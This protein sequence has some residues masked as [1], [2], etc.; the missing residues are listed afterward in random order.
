[1]HT[2]H[3][4]KHFPAYYIAYLSVSFLLRIVDSHELEQCYGR[5]RH[6]RIPLALPS[7]R[8]GL[9]GTVSPRRL[10]Y[11]N[12]VQLMLRA[13]S[14]TPVG[15][16]EEEDNGDESPPKQDANL[17]RLS[18]PV[19]V[20]VRTKF[21]RAATVLDQKVEL[22]LQRRR[23]IGMLKE[24]LRRVLPNKPPVS[25]MQIVYEGRIQGDDVLI[26]EI[27]E[28]E[29]ED[30]EEEEEE[31]EETKG[32]LVFTLD[33]IPPVDGK[34]FHTLSRQLNDLTTSELLRLYA[35]NEAALYETSLSLLENR[36]TEEEGTDEETNLPSSL[37]QVVPTIEERANQIES[38][39]TDMLCLQKEDKVRSILEETRPP[40]AIQQQTEIR[41]ERI[42]HATATGGMRVSL[43]KKLQHNFNVQSWQDTIRSICLFVFF[44]LFGGR[45]PMKR[46]ILLLGAPS[47]LL[48][49][50]RPV[51]LLW[52]QL[53]YAIMN[54]PPG[55]VLSLL[56][57]P[58]QALFHRDTETAMQTLYGTYTTETRDIEAEKKKK[59]RKLINAD[60]AITEEFFDAEE[61]EFFD[62]IDQQEDDKEF[63]D[64]D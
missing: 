2:P 58:Q 53:L 40:S 39:L 7:D 25:L 56:P 16:D 36:S 27:V 33:M 15:E 1:M 10:R 6:H 12:A 51:K 37:K 60:K 26:D 45:T 13:G 41:G 52:K 46:L 34:F 8:G 11:D 17:D 57:A 43:R 61:E 19:S 64:D 3:K 48:L 62:T 24:N 18:T 31:E 30:D 23:N 35:S 5:P 21:G 38:Q 49:Q 20:V 50:A 4:R 54:D 28:E 44:G 63:D 29:D 59:R 32:K 9:F 22:T 14:Q 42:V 55:I 47:V